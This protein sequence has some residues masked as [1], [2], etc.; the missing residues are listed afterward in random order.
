VGTNYYH[1]TKPPCECCGREFPRVHIGKSSVGWTF[2]FHGGDEGAEGLESWADWHRR[3]RE[4]GRIVDEYGDEISFDG[5][6]ELVESK[7]ASPNNQ[8]LYCR[9]HHREFSG[10]YWLDSEGNSFG[11]GNFS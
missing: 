7:R 5:F 10:D 4:G 2:S 11:R 9:V 3:L 1:E 6:V 8:T